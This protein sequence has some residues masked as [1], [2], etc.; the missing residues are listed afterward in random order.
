[1]TWI[2]SVEEKVYQNNRI[3]IPAV[4]FQDSLAA[5]FVEVEEKRRMEG[6]CLEGIVQIRE[7]SVRRRIGEV[8]EDKNR[9]I[10]DGK[11]YAQAVN[12]QYCLETDPSMS[13]WNRVKGS[14][15]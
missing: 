8:A 3:D 9:E 10:E 5:I 14:K 15:K 11:V 4:P 13:D 12:R 7:K 6:D 2:L 1:M